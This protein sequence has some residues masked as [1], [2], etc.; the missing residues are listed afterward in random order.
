MIYT[1]NIQ[2]NTIWLLILL[3]CLI[4]IVFLAFYFNIMKPFT[5]TRDYIKTEMQRT[6]GEERLFWKNK[7]K[8][9]YILH[10]PIIG[11]LVIKFLKE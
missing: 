11:R 7:L 1:Q 3:I 2:D 6:E 10:I 5:E 4:F 8:R 9:W